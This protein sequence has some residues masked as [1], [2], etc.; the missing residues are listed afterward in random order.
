MESWGQA[1]KGVIVHNFQQGHGITFDENTLPIGLW[2]ITLKIQIK[3]AWGQAGK[4]VIAHNFQWGYAHKPIS[5][6]KLHTRTDA[7]AVF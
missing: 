4:G 3:E 1:S 6:H 2:P 5:G 7:W